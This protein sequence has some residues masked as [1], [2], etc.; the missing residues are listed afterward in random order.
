MSSLTED[1]L[2]VAI[3][4]GNGVL[5]CREHLPYG[6][7]GAELVALTTAGLV[8]VTDGRLDLLQSAVSTGD[9]DLDA[10]LGTLAAAKQPPKLRRWLSKPRRKI[11]NS[12]LDRL[13]AAGAIQR[14]GGALRPRWPVTDSARAA[15]L[16]GRLDAIVL[17]SGEVDEAEAAYAGL[18]DAVGLAAYLYR[19][20]ENRSV[21]SRLGDLTKANP[22]TEAVRRTVAAAQAAAAG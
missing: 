12:Y 1:L 16:R 11:M 10:A 6:L 17:G 14:T 22:I 8:E 18:V 2:L 21:R 9:V 20:R 19:G 4:P 7:M 3:D 5:H 15:A 13:I